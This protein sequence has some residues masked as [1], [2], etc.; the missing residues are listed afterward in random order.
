MPISPL[1][2]LSVACVEPRPPQDP[3]A[4]EKPA[5]V[6]PVIPPLLGLHLFDLYA[7][8][9]TG[10]RDVF[11][12]DLST[13]WRPA[14]GS[15]LTLVLDA[16]V[17]ADRL[18]LTPCTASPGARYR[19]EVNGGFA[20]V[21]EP[22][23]DGSAL[24][25]LGAGGAGW[26]VATTSV[27]TAGGLPGT[28]L[29]ELE[30]GARG[31]PIP[32]RPPRQVTAGVRASSV[33]PP[34]EAHHPSLLFD[35]RLDF[36]W[37]LGRGGQGVGESVELAF[38]E[39]VGVLG[40]E[41][42]N[43][44]QG[45]HERFEAA[46][47]AKTLSIGVDSTPRISVPVEDVEGPQRLWLPRMAVGRRLELAVVDARPGGSRPDLVLSELRLLDLFGPLDVVVDARDARATA[48]VTGIAGTPLERALDAVHASICGARTLVVRSDLRFE[49]TV[50]SP[51]ARRAVGDWSSPRSAGAWWTID[52]QGVENAVPSGWVEPEAQAPGRPLPAGGKVELARVEALGREAFEVELATWR[53]ANRALAACVASAGAAEGINAFDLMV[54]R[55]ALLIR[56][57]LGTDVLTE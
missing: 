26:R 20:G 44:D 56:G 10:A 51:E 25:Q 18:V 19:V 33:L 27:R 53:R 24:L 16:P 21:A 36:G 35:H 39:P 34:T 28:C 40:V 13:G 3:P 12:G 41:L 42:W 7:S 22:S 6:L 8:A 31:A 43:G 2:L 47:R 57:A 1:L 29:G 52:V 38:K 55:D 14:P 17:T 4:P 45:S 11:D 30:I 5:A 15:S 32:L 23:A 37:V 9:G 54:K 48:V 46:P 49:S 50:D